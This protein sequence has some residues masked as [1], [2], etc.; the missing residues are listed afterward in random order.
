MFI[1]LKIEWHKAFNGLLLVFQIF[2]LCP[3]KIDIKKKSHHVGP[4]CVNILLIALSVAQIALIVSLIFFAGRAFFANDSEVS[5][6]NN[7]LKF[8]IMILTHFVTIVECLVVRQNFIEI[9]KRIRMI[10]N[11]I[12]GMIDN[13]QSLL[14]KFYMSTTRKLILCIIF[15]TIMELLIIVN[16]LDMPSWTF[17]WN[18]SIVSLSMSRLRHLQHTLYIDLLTCRFKLIKKELKAIVKLTKYDSNLLIAKN[19]I[20]YESLFRKIGTI[21]NI[22]NTLWETSLLINRSFGISQLANLLQN[23]IQLTCDLYMIYSVLYKNNLSHIFGEFSRKKYFRKLLKKFPFFRT[24]ISTLSDDTNH[25]RGVECLR[26]MFG[27]SA[28]YRISVAQHRKRHR[29]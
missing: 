9:W 17:M 26:G 23:F 22:Y 21:K 1:Q 27:S 6:F 28:I 2:G 14:E 5:S 11:L 10:D 25:H 29:R 12:D 19:E 18:I 8:A 3:I 20:F 24:F 15:T 13:Y 16:I 7:I 4:S